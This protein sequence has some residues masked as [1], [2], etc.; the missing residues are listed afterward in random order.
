MNTM[1]RVTVVIPNW[2][3]LKWLGPCLRSLRAQSFKG[4][5]TIVVDNGSEDGSIHFLQSEFPEVEIVALPKNVGFAAGMNA[6]IRAAHGE[7]IAALNNDTEAHPEWLTRMVEVMD[8]KPE[9]AIFASKIMNY[10]Q[11]DIFDSLGDGY[12]RSGLAFHLATES[13][14]DGSIVEPFEVFG[15]CAAACFYRRSMLDEIGLYDDDFFA[16]MED[17]DL[18][19]RARMAGYRCLAVPQAVVYHV[20]SASHGGTASAFSVRLTARNILLVIIKNIPA[21][22]LPRVLLTTVL[23]QSAVVAEAL[24]TGRRPWLRKHIG[25]YFKGLGDAMSALP[26]TLR[27]RKQILLLRRISARQFS[28]EITRAQAQLRAFNAKFPKH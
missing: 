26:A 7:Y 13:R 9:F 2:N 3:G 21:T 6:G 14:D 18:C 20:G 23:V 8:A 22:M 25:A 17:V 10:R 27:K 15:A 5:R 24:F 12:R 4:F 28:R 16:Y 11:R 19:I 1:D